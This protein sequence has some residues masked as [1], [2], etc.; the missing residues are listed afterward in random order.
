MVGAGDLLRRVNFVEVGARVCRLPYLAQETTLSDSYFGF[1]VNFTVGGGSLRRG[2]YLTNPDDELNILFE[3]R[4]SY[5]R[6]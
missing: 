5:H 4:S 2:W 1:C 6:G 3:S